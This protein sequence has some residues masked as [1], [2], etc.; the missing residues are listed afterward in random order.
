VGAEN[1]LS[2][3]TASGNNVNRLS[4]THR[5]FLNRQAIT[6]AV[7]DEFG[8][9]STDG[10]ENWPEE[11]HDFFKAAGIIFP[12]PTANGI[13]PQF[14]PDVPKQFGDDR[15][16]KYVFP[17]DCGPFVTLLRTAE[18]GCPTLVV[19]GSKQPLA[20]VSWA[21]E[22]WG[23]VGLPG[24][25]NWVG[26]DLTWADGQNV[27]LMFDADVASNRNVWDAAACL[28]ESLEVEGAESVSFAY[29]AGAKDTEGLDDVL[30]RRPE[31][32]RAPY[33]ER[34]AGLARKTLPKRPAA[35]KKSKYFDSSGGLLAETL[36]KEV[37]TNRPCALAEEK[38]RVVTYQNGVYGLDGVGLIA[39]VGRLLG[40]QHRPAHLA[41]AEQR[42]I[43]LLSDSGSVIPD[44]VS[45][46]LLNCA[47]GMLDL[48]TGELHPH[49]PKYLS[50]AQIPVT[51]DPEATCPRYEVWLKDRVGDQM[52]D[53]EESTSVMLD[54][55]RTPPKAVFAFGPSHSGKSTFIRITE[56]IAGG[57]E[58]RCAVSLHQLSDD[59][60]MASNLYGKMLN[61]TADLSSNDVS[62]I[63]TFKKMT[64]EDTIQANRKH[65]K[66]FAFRNTAL[67]LFSANALPSVSESSRAYVNRI[68]P[69]EF[70]HSFEGREDSSIEDGI[71]EELPGILVRWVKAW[72]RLKARGNYLPTDDRVMAEFESR[73]DRVTRWLTTRCVITE[74]SPGVRLP[75][76]QCLTPVNL[77]KRFKLDQADSGATIMGRDTFL[78]RVRKSKGIVV[79]RTLTGTRAL[80]VAVL[81]NEEENEANDQW[82]VGQSGGQTEFDITAGQSDAGQS[83]Q[84]DPH[85]GMPE[86]SSPVGE[87]ESDLQMRSNS[88]KLPT[89]PAESLISGNVTGSLPTTLPTPV[90]ALP[91]VDGSGEP[92]LPTPSD[93]RLCGICDVP[94]AG[95]D[96]A[97]TLA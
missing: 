33:L 84:F 67:F 23:V 87:G 56:R 15:P 45:D 6:D 4:K 85:K 1:D 2:E 74:T 69:F 48:R 20:A 55:S 53:L 47:N 9:V 41:T 36:A 94:E 24:C 29:L 7:L 12:W 40:E 93:D 91:A 27:V 58:N 78:D 86:F 42:L 90:S 3:S 16:L 5:E 73:S 17:K 10:Q 66:Q 30:G 77:Y 37:Q 79:V 76:S 63:S 96:C 61:T 83:G 72:Q 35:A 52:D 31:D 39:E 68:K 50:R 49:D 92:T 34:L 82:G 88:G 81:P 62:D 89:L 97:W 25:N 54:Q 64:G 32:K 21:P 18:D 38:T 26:A 11:I 75:E 22:G 57:T 60:F 44:Y 46:P 59:K 13:V 19:E 71:M 51:W 14:R 80:N 28:K 65:G 95:H 8:I 43:G 70:P